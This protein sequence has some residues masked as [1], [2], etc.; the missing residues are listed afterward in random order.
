MSEN[1][2]RP[3]VDIKR[4]WEMLAEMAAYL[5]RHVWDKKKKERQIAK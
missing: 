5:R 3:L 1:E 4:N 2:S